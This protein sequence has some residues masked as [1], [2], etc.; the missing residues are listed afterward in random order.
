MYKMLEPF[1]I[2]KQCPPEKRACIRDCW[3]DDD[4]VW[5]MIRDGW[6]CSEDHAH[7][8]SLDGAAQEVS[9]AARLRALRM[10]FAGVHK[11]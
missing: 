7:T 4:G 1:E 10:E 6:E 8:I 9:K 2:M 5:V 11:V 3:E